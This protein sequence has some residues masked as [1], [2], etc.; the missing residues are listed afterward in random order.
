LRSRTKRGPRDWCCKKHRS[1]GGGKVFETNVEAIIE[2][3]R[4]SRNIAIT[5]DSADIESCTPGSKTVRG[6]RGRKTPYT[7]GEAESLRTTGRRVNVWERGEDST[8]K[9]RGGKKPS[10]RGKNL[11]RVN[12]R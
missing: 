1:V 12:I 3:F 7:A 5:V 4:R 6:E 10:D 9:T 8:E 11:G 2:T